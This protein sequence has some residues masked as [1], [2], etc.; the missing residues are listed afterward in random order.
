M[1]WSALVLVDEL[2]LIGFAQPVLRPGA[3]AKPGQRVINAL[4]KRAQRQAQRQRLSVAHGE[5][6]LARAT[7]PQRK[8]RIPRGIGQTG[9]VDLDE[10]R[11]LGR[12][13]ARDTAKRLAEAR[14]RRG[15]CLRG[16]TI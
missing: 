12:D 10:G 2:L 13:V 8:L 16:E 11:A 14:R 7:R 4:F 9:G 5:R 15:S 6:R 3:V 1:G